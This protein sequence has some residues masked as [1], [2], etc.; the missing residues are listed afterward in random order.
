MMLQ[1]AE[2]EKWKGAQLEK[3]VQGKVH[4]C[5]RS[6]KSTSKWLAHVENHH[7]EEL[8]LKEE[9]ENEE[10]ENDGDEDF[11]FENL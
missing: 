5:Y 1:A 2:D 3:H 11:D 9:E 6:Y 7:R 10:E 4:M 8:W